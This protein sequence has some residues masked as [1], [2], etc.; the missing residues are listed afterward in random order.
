MA[1]TRRAAVLTARLQSLRKDDVI[2]RHAIEVEILRLGAA[3]ERAKRNNYEVDMLL[4]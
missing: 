4:G 1:I 2:S 3:Y